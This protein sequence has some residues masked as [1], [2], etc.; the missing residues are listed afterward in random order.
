V[1]G[2]VVVVVGDVEGPFI[3]GVRWWGASGVRRGSSRPLMALG[4]AAATRRLGR[5]GRTG[6]GRQALEGPRVLCL[7]LSGLE[8]RG[9][10]TMR[11]VWACAWVGHRK[12]V[13][14]LTSGR[15]GRVVRAGARVGAAGSGRAR[16][17]V[18]GAG[19]AQAKQEERR[20]K[21][22]RKRKKGKIKGKKKKKGRERKR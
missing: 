21:E 9:G 8:R 10:G 4:V 12:A 22:K 13:A 2:R 1:A 7:S 3:G 11:A 6:V 15:R 5:A 20:R 16:T 19:R 17:C 18:Q 14:V